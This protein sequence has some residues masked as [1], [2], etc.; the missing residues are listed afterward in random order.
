MI[1]L[2]ARSLA[3]ALVAIFVVPLGH[4]AAET[5]LRFAASPQ[6]GKP[7]DVVIARDTTNPA[8]VD[9]RITVW[10]DKNQNCVFDQSEAVTTSMTILLPGGLRTS[11]QKLPPLPSDPAPSEL[12][13]AAEIDGR[14]VGLKANLA[15]AEGMPCSPQGGSALADAARRLLSMPRRL[16]L[17]IADLGGTFRDALPL[18][19]VSL[20]E[21]IIATGNTQTILSDPRYNFV[22]PAFSPNGKDLVFVADGADGT[23]LELLEM[24][25]LKRRTLLSAPGRSDTAQGISTPV[26]IDATSVAIVRDETAMVVPIAGGAPRMLAP[27]IKHLVAVLPGPAAKLIAEA[28]DPTAP[29]MQAWYALTMADP[30]EPRQRLNPGVPWNAVRLT[31]AGSSEGAVEL[32]RG[33]AKLFQVGMAAH[34]LGSA[35]P[36]CGLSVAWSPDGEILVLARGHL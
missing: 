17:R 16:A 24:A 27:Q 29:G 25:S 15:R 13:L 19:C 11:H 9:F 33:R 18:G 14:L 22:S 28:P 32:D 26:W 35:N 1:R 10:T 21:V 7:I 34:D 5:S 20:D 23:Q 12:G 6:R 4:L 30:S 3:G 36:Q 8:K 31:Y 2:A